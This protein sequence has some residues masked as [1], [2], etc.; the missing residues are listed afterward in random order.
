[1]ASYYHCCNFCGHEFAGPTGARMNIEHLCTHYY[2]G[3]VVTGW[4]LECWLWYGT[5]REREYLAA[6]GQPYDYQFKE[7]SPEPQAV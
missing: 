5:G 6:I 1:M 2:Y 7:W 4:K 3:Q